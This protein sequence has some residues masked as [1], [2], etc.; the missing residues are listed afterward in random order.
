VTAERRFGPFALVGLIVLSLGFGS[1][2]SV[3]NSRAADTVSDERLFQISS[4]DLTNGPG[5]TTFS[6]RGL[7]PGDEVSAAITL[8]NPGRDPMSYVLRHDLVP[9]DGTALA[10]ALILTIKTAGSSCI[11]YDGITLYDGPLDQAAFG[12]EGIG[13]LL[14]A[15]TAEILC[16]RAV[17]PSAADNALQGM[18]TSVTLTFGAS[19]QAARR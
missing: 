19:W 16:F 5:V 2:A 1:D 4:F 7:M 8:A 9:A 17:L 18:S 13:R 15:A 11:D 14:P 10:A 3:S 6:A 12:S